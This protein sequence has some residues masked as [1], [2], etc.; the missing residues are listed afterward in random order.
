MR[1]AQLFSLAVLA[2]LAAPAA[3]SNM[4]K[5]AT[6]FNGAVDLGALGLASSG[7]TCTGYDEWLLTWRS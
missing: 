7:T 6:D 4:C 2:V 5:N 3:A 1:E